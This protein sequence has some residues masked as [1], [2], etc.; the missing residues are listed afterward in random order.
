MVTAGPKTG[1]G[2]LPSD[3]S[4]LFYNRQ[5]YST[6]TD[7]SDFQRQ[8]ASDPKGARAARL[9][10]FQAATFDNAEL[11]VM[12][13]LGATGLILTPSYRHDVNANITSIPKPS[14]RAAVSRE[15]SRLPDTISLRSVTRF[16]NAIPKM[17]AKI[18]TEALEQGL[19]KTSEQASIQNQTLANYL[20]GN[21]QVVYGKLLLKNLALSSRPEGASA[22]GVLGD[23]GGVAGRRRRVA[24]PSPVLDARSGSHGEPATDV[25]PHEPRTFEARARPTIRSRT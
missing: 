4:V 10:D 9:Y 15:S 3:D 25:D 23:Q 22:G 13:E 21:N 12:S 24:P 6:S 7:L 14:P 16:S 5:L 18:E 20:I 1:F 19:E 11:T 8:L 17:R 2:L